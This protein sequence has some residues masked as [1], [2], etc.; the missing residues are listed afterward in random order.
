VPGVP[1]VPGDPDSGSF[2]GEGSGA[3]RDIL[4]MEF[5]AQDSLLG[6]KICIH[7]PPEGQQVH[8]PILELRKK[9]I[10]AVSAKN[11]SSSDESL[12]L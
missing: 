7:E 9:T 8:I 5:K 10:C 4:E 1:R 3:E 2:V 12:L 6:L 11:P